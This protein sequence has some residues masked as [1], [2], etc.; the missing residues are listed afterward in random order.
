MRDLCRPR[1]MRTE[2]R[3]SGHV[4]SLR[5]ASSRS[6]RLRTRNDDVTS[7][8]RAMSLSKFI[9]TPNKNT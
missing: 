7:M 2:A 4:S 9:W 3:H 5:R 8:S 6:R 1:S